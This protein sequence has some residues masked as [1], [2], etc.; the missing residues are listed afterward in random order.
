MPR[1]PVAEQ[2]VQAEALSPVAQSSVVSPELQGVGAR[3]QVQLGQSL[4]NAADAGFAILQR[5]KERDD[6]TE[7]F[8]G[9]AAMRAKAIQFESDTK[10]ARRADQAKGVT[11]DADKWWQEQTDQALET[12]TDPRRRR[13]L[14]QSFTRMRLQSLDNFQAYEDHQGDVAHDASWKASKALLISD[15]AADPKRVPDT[16]Q[17]IKQKNA[18]YAAFKGLGADVKD[19]LD[20]EDTTRLHT[21]VLQ[22]MVRRDPTA[23]KA[24]F[25]ANKGQIA[26]TSYDTITKAVDTAS[27][28]T[29]GVKASDE[30]WRALGPKSYNEPVV[31]DKMESAIRAKYPDDAV[32]QKAAISDLRERVAAHNSTQ[33]EV[34]AGS[35][36]SVMDVYAR[37]KSL[38]EV[39]KAPE[40]QTLGGSDRAKIEDY[41][42]AHQTAAI[43]RGNAALNRE[44]LLEQRE[45]G[46]KQR[47]GFG[48]YLTYSNPTVLSGMSEAQVQALLP[49]L[50]N[51]LTGHLMEKKRALGSAQAKLEAKVDTDDFNSIARRIGLNP[52]ERSMSENMKGALG[53]L[54]FRT[55]QLIDLA[56]RNKKGPLTRDEKFE[57]INQE[58]TRTVTIPGFFGGTT[59]PVILLKPEE[60]AKIQVP[61]AERKQIAE[62]MRV[63]FEKTRDPAFAPS[64]TNLRRW[65]LRVK[66]PSAGLIPD[67]K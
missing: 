43:N 3:Q 38:T 30:V 32:R 12:V 58:I 24:Y 50:G 36:N 45:Q 28:A 29:D 67:A 56:Q 2:R 60:V 57:L 49:S 37:T 55:E 7:V 53:E 4:G 51:E 10:K 25:E 17:Q 9:E 41:I 15:G 48:A 18:Y 42:V 1:V 39:M 40:W 27:A 8:N 52:D 44:N 23:A 62:A 31:L 6:A 20:L 59:K 14:A 46:A 61:V 13:L 26:G 22:Q 19:A 63:Q 65:Y 21:E 35:I 11:G 47:R 66:S 5:Q 64:E 16:I 34:K 54:K 33:A